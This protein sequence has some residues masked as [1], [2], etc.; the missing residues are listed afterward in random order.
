MNYIFEGMEVTG[1]KVPAPLERVLKVLISP[2][3]GNTN[4]FTLLFSIISPGNATG[5]HTHA[6][7]DEVMYVAAGQGEAIVGDE[8]REIRKDAIIFAPKLVEHSVKNTRDETLK[9]VCFYVPPLKPSGY[10]EQAIN[11]AN[12]YFRSL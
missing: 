2:E 10:Y 1:A 12:E 7:A 4:K 11:K 6:R 9:L 3:L 8:K 5:F